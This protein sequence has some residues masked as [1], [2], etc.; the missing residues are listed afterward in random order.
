MS[1]RLSASRVR[2]ERAAITKRDEAILAD[3]ARVRLLTATQIER[4]HFTEGTETSRARRARRTLK[5]LHERGLLTRLNR[6]V[7]GVHAGSAGYIYGLSTLG[8]AVVDVSGPA[9]GQRR[10]R[11]WEPSPM[12]VD[13]VLEVSEV[14]VC[15][16]ELAHADALIELLEFQAEPAAWRNF[17]SIRSERITLKPDAYVR[18][19]IGQFEQVSFVEVDRGTEHAPT[20]KRKLGVYIDAYQAGVEQ[21]NGSPFPA[22]IWIVPDDKRAAQLKRIIDTMPPEHAAV[23]AVT[24]PNNQIQA[25]KGGES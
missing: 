1:V 15:L 19:G 17:L 8:Q 16:R 5:R 10:R 22:V 2:R 11:P 9:G 25:L 12:F 13:H 20:L 3:V 24:T 6:R 21:R 4:M 7:G 23:F 14:F 18:L